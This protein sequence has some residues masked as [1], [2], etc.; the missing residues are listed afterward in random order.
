MTFAV[1]FQTADEHLNTH[2]AKHPAPRQCLVISSDRQIQNY[3]KSRG[4]IPV[5]SLEWWD[6]VVSGEW[7]DDP[8][9]TPVTDEPKPEPELTPEERDY[10]RRLFET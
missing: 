10:W 1:N 8:I 7:T 4:A 2:L 6:S 9:A 5:D 3:A